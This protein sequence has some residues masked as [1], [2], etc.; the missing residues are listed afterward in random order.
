MKKRD[1]REKRQERRKDDT[2]RSNKEIDNSA[3]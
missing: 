2:K 1:E 3:R